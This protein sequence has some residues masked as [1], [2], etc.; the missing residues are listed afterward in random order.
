[1]KRISLII[2]AFVLCTGLVA[3]GNTTSSVKTTTNDS[4]KTQDATTASGSSEGK[5]VAGMVWYNFGDT[6]ITA[7]R[8]AVDNAAKGSNIEIDAADSQ[9]DMATQTNNINN[10]LTKGVDY[11]CINNINPNA[12]GDYINRAKE[13][14]IPIIFVNC[15]SPNEEALMSYDKVYHISSAAEQSGYI[16]GDLA[17]EY[18]A[19]N[20]GADRNGNGK[21]DY[22]MLVG[23]Q[24]N[25]DSKMRT[26]KSI[27]RVIENGIEVN[28]IQETICNFQ[29]VEAQ[30]Q[31]AS[32]IAANRDDIDVVFANNDDMALGAIEALKAA[33]FFK[34]ED[35]YIPVLGVD[36]TNVGIE[37]INEGTLLG[38]SLNNPVALGNTVYKVIELLNEGKEINSENVGHTMSENGKHIW[39]DYVQI[40]A[41]NTEDASY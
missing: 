13:K 36:A 25:Y 12:S 18:W 24:G 10:L 21:M 34:N 26:E 33:G 16:Q 37:A 1:M 17:S 29:R 8:K 41:E 20:Q 38:T 31:V 2:T 15:D 5:A 7:V 9:F 28:C 19:A 6:F 14:D 35:T 40:T 11:L 32:I 30:N 39:L 22:I 27:E 3:C 23:M 4:S